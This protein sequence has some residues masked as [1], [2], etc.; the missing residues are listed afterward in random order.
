[1]RE[2]LPQC[3]CHN[4][5]DNLMM[6]N[7]GK[8]MDNE[9]IVKMN[10]LVAKMKEAAEAYYNGQE[11]MSD[12]EYDALFD[13][14]KKLEKEAGFVLPDS[15]T[16]NVVGAKPVDGSIKIIHKYPALSLSKTKSPDDLRTFL[17]Q[18][19][20]RLSWKLDGL[21]LVATYQN[22]KLES[23]VT[24][25]NGLV[26]EDITRNAPY[27]QGVALSIPEK[28]EVVIR[29]EALCSYKSF[30]K[31]NASIESDE[32]KYKNARGVASGSVRLQDG[33][34]LERREICFIPFELVSPKVNTI[35]E[36]IS[37]IHS[38]GMEFVEGYDVD[39][40]NLADV[41]KAFSKKVENKMF[42]YPTDGLVLAYE[43]M[44]YG[45]NLGLTGHHPKHSIAFKWKDEEYPTVLREIFWSASKTGLLN[46]VA[47]FDPVEID[48]TTVKRA[49]VHNI[50][51]IEHLKLQV[52]DHVTVY[53]ANMIIPQIAKN[54]DANKHI[55]YHAEIPRVCPVCGG[56]TKVV[57]NANSNTGE[58]V[59][60]LYCRNLLCPSKQIGEW[61]HFVSRDAMNIE[62]LGEK[63][64][65]DLIDE[66]I[67]K[68]YSDLFTNLVPNK[69][70]ITELDG[71]G[72]KS[73]N[74][75]I[76]G[77]EKAKKTTLANFINA[78]SIPGVGKSTA[79]LI[80]S[81]YEQSP[82]KFLA[83]DFETTVQGLR[84]ID[85]IGDSVVNTLIA[86]SREELSVM[87]C[88]EDLKKLA[89]YFQFEKA[90]TGDRLKGMTFVITGS[91]NHY[92]NRD[93]MIAVIESLG[94]KVSGSVSSKTK[95]LI[96]NDV[97]STSGKNKKAKE[98]NVPII[99]ED[100]F[101]ANYID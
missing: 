24:R 67:L 87:S 31:I 84:Q 25:G 12:F 26:G 8:R 11:I 66:G 16:T 53:K 43:D 85:G 5:G 33:K 47:V 64:I 55:E 1:M 9:M 36:M 78:L 71:W 63:Q 65:M 20:G 30:E 42:P 21:T 27:I 22:G 57:V 83:D 29:G 13:E 80:S 17:G 45:R 94:G 74:V 46:P 56:L 51:Y 76:S 70:K 96:N 95:A 62:G 54:E 15:P 3:F 6:I 72:E 58:P 41:I 73:F 28:E 7:G 44:E 61:T 34:E 2:K 98:L 4:N 69:D 97:N 18:Q 52:G 77:V 92:E 50:S 60:T 35:T 68:T 59:K 38:Y 91:L 93:A 90:K 19:I 99:S 23:L 10:G 79:K 89:S 86:W 39:E 48:G 81:Y 75:I 14:L 101:I 40:K 100:D 49:S 82:E 32:E 37:R 88:R